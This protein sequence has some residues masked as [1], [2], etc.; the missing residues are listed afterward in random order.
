A[1][2]EAMFALHANPDDPALRERFAVGPDIID[3]L[4][5]EAELRNWIDALVI[6]SRRR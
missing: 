5:R 3:P 6:P 4:Y 1:Y 2:A